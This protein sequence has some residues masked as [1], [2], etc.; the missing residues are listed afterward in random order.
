M[1]C[2]L[3]AQYFEILDDADPLRMKMLKSWPV[4]R[5]SRTEISHEE[6]HDPLRRQSTNSIRAELCGDVVQTQMKRA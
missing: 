5:Y 1:K 3:D 4:Y 2:V 6:P